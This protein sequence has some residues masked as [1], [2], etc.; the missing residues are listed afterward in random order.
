MLIQL[1]PFDRRPVWLDDPAHIAG[2]AEELTCQMDRGIPRSCCAGLNR[3]IALS[4]NH[5]PYHFLGSI[6]CPLRLVAPRARFAASDIRP[7]IA[8]SGSAL[9]TRHNA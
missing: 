9:Q 6:S 2:L 1:R 4:E 5:V 8:L 7:I 3:S